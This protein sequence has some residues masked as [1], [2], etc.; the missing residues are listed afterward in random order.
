MN[1][2]KLS[3]KNQP[4]YFIIV[5]L[6][7]STIVIV[8][9]QNK[10]NHLEAGFQFEH[11]YTD[12][13][14]DDFKTKTI[15]C[16]QALKFTNT[17]QNLRLKRIGFVFGENTCL[18]CLENEFARIKKLNLEDQVL[19]FCLTP[20]IRTY[21]SYLANELAGFSN[22]YRITTENKLLSEMSQPIYL[23]IG[24]NTILESF[25]TPTFSNPTDN[26]IKNSINWMNDSSIETE[27][28]IE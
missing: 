3:S 1:I 25:Y 9:R 27:M 7:A 20:D 12:W 14:S 21:K 19:V 6:V 18:S 17:S 22:V 4:Y 2:N 26:W 10:I 11:Q 28:S 24:N 23:R 15:L 5:I 16:G 13:L 8:N